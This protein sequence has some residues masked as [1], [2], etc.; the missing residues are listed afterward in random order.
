M[1][2]AKKLPSGNWRVRVYDYTDDQG[3]KHYKSFTYENKSD[4]EYYAK[5]YQRE[6][7]AEKPKEELTVGDAID[8]YI[9]LSPMLSPTTLARYKNVREHGF[10][11]LMKMKVSD[12]NDQTVQTEINKEARRPVERTGKPLAPKTVKNEYGVI[13]S[14]LYTV[15][16]VRFNIRLPKVQT[17][18]KE[19]PTPEA[20]I[21]LLKGT[22][23]ELPCLL[24]IWLSFSLSEIRG[25][26]CSSV[27]DGYIYVDQVLVEVNNLPVEK[28]D[29][30]VDSRNRRQAIPKY[31]MDLIEQQESWVNYTA[32]GVDGPLIALNRHQIYNRYKRIMEKAGFDISFHDL[33]HMFASIMLTRLQIPEKV[34]QDE[35]GWSTPHVM[36]KVYSNT[37][38]DSRKS[39]DKIR[40]DYFKG[41]L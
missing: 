1:A 9:D 13:S 11:D 17:K 36:K 39:A 5:K 32:T 40:D 8:R 2:R 41:L 15:C 27:R 35:G 7:P 31:I 20:V 3:K 25:F 30:K 34:V 37:F 33:R 12:L 16:G 4:A 18:P 38:S 19:L 28:T 26:R 29:A 6:K 23:I 22:S 21:S 10:P 14:S 24:S